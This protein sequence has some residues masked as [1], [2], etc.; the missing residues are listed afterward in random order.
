[1]AKII[2]LKNELYLSSKS[3]YHNLEGGGRVS[4]EN[5]LNH[6]YPIGSIFITT[7][8]QDPSPYLGG[9]WESFG[10]GRVLVGFDSSQIEF[11]TILKTGGSKYIQQHSHKQSLQ[12]SGNRVGVAGYTWAVTNTGRWYDGSDLA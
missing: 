11:N 7:V 8:N 2:K 3:I 1:M 10:A 5:A 9:K 6:I 4:L 12:D